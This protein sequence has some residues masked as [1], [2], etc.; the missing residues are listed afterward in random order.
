MIPRLLLITDR[1]LTNDL[2]AAIAQA[3]AGGV[4]HILLREKDLDDREWIQLAN[5]IRQSLAGLTAHLL[6][7]G[8]P[9]LLQATGA[10]GVH[11][12]QDGIDVAKTRAI[13]GEGKLIGRSCHDDASAKQAFAEGADYITLSP[14]FFTHSHP[15]VTPLGL[16]KFSKILRSLHQPVL[17]LG[18]INTHTIQQALTT[19]AHGVAMVRGILDQNNPQS[20][21]NNIV[22]QIN[23]FTHR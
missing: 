12:P 14:L 7:S 9:H 10:I 18:G 11:L 13:L 21:A 19:G 5:S 15:N 2:A 3:V 6:I 4:T 16:E 20:Q 23:R 22:S 8:R 17:A 1:R